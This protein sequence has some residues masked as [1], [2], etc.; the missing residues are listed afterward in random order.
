MNW[1]SSNYCQWPHNFPP[2][3]EFQFQKDNFSLLRFSFSIHYSNNAVLK[4]RFPLFKQFPFPVFPFPKP[5]FDKIKRNITYTT[6]KKNFLEYY[7]LNQKA[8]LILFFKFFF[9]L[10]HNAFYLLLIIVL[11]C[12]LL[13][14]RLYS[15]RMGSYER[16]V[17][18]TSWQKSI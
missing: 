6:R 17:F 9:I 18:L 14:G 2:N 1:V 13:S 15:S 4:E 8:L 10:K 12:C 16:I 5:N 3:F 11:F 7:G